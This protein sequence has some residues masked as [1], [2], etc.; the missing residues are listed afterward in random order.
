M[1]KHQVN[2]FEIIKTYIYDRLEKAIKPLEVG[3]IE[4]ELEEVKGYMTIFTPEQAA[5]IIAY[6]KI[7]SL[8]TVTE[9][10]WS[11]MIKELKMH[12][13]V[14]HE[15]GTIVSSE[16]QQK[17]DLQWWTRDVKKEIETYYWS[18]YKKFISQTLPYEV[19]KTID[20]DTDVVMNNLA[21]PQ[22]EVQFSRYGM[23]V[24]HVQSGK[25]GNYSALVSKA[26]DAGYKFIVI[27]A[28]GLNNLRNQTQERLNESFIGR[29][30]INFVG[31]GNFANSDKKR[32]PVSL[33]TKVTDFNKSDA[34]GAKQ[35][36]DLDMGTRPIILVIKK[37]TRTLTN[38]IEWLKSHYQEEVKDHAMLLIDDESDYASI[39]TKDENNPTSINKKIRELIALFRK[40]AYVAYTATP[41][42]NIFIDYKAE[43]KEFGKDLF[44]EDFIYALEAPTSYFGAAKIF[45]DPTKKYLATVKDHLDIIPAIHKRDLEIDE[46]PK[47]LEE[48][49]RLFIL[50][51]AIRHLRRQEDKHNSMMIHVTRFTR[52]HHRIY[53]KVSE[54]L[55][56]IQ[57]A[58]V[59]HGE[60]SHESKRINNPYIQSL[61]DTFINIYSCLEFDWAT[62]LSKLNEV[63]E[64]I[65]TREVH[66]DKKIELEYPKDKAVNFIVVGG[67]SLARGYT[68]EGLSVSYFL[69]TT[70]FYDT[71][72]QMG[73]WFGYRQNYEDLC[74]MYMTNTTFNSFTTIIEATLDLVDSLRKMARLKLTPRDFGLAVQQHPDSGLQVTARNKLKQTKDI[75]FEMKLDGHLKETSWIPA[76]ESDTKDNINLIENLVRNLGITTLN[77]KKPIIWEEKNRNIVIDFLNNFKFYSPESDEFGMY[78]RMPV[79]FV[80]AYA[81][82]ID[83]KWDI[84]LFKGQ[85]EEPIMID[86]VKYGQLQERQLDIKDDRYEFRN[87][88]VSS[89]NAEEVTLTKEEINE[90]KENQE[91]KKYAKEKRKQGLVED[92]LINK[93]IE[94]FSRRK[95]ARE[96]LKRP[97]LMLHLVD[98]TL[99]SDSENSHGK[100]KVVGA[101]SISFPTTIESG[102]RNI[103]L[104]VN[105]VY[106]DNLER[107]LAEQEDSDD[108][109]E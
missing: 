65:D 23:V 68:L 66:I 34:T 61:Q 12:F 1:I 84:V 58:I 15:R 18:R 38:V 49:I 76:N 19:V 79:N 24:G 13:D 9:D 41:Y 17:R 64:L 26:A 75:Y 91:K 28:G 94:E 96:K 47:S 11:R 62:V 108:D 43:S 32:T 51:V 106:L 74:K 73:R 3:Q 95:A 14:T 63:V 54:Y 56:K 93:Q 107:S 33:T 52:V 104:K 55:E 105:Q 59:V 31:V 8:I 30:G 36:L 85:S 77:E 57:Q 4:K 60:F 20:E 81:K 21:N 98:A 16:E 97:L 35:G 53:L 37:N 71:L 10:E 67:S 5:G 22:N 44:P 87:R 78:S 80:K 88:Q 46:L 2:N 103:K 86:G 92:D 42:A 70:V 39:N 25:T 6:N 90:L 29:E 99:I 69:R 50:N 40:S 27:I 83:I 48:A 45:L 100:K 102:N 82:D 101:F 89:G 72:M 109:I 7:E